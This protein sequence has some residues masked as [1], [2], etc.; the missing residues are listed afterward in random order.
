MIKKV[1]PFAKPI[2]I[3]FTKLEAEAVS[4]WLDDIDWDDIHIA[5]DGCS[6]CTDEAHYLD[7][8]N[9]TWNRVEGQAWK[10]DSDSHALTVFDEVGLECLMR[11]KDYCAEADEPV[12]FVH[13]YH[14]WKHPEVP[15]DQREE[16]RQGHFAAN[17]AAEKIKKALRAEMTE[18]E[19][20]PV[21][22]RNAR[23][24]ELTA[25]AGSLDKDELSRMSAEE[26]VRRLNLKGRA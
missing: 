26:I 13:R 17:R 16:T 25:F 1:T 15:E 11:T 4:Y 7:T 20:S 12:G 9:Y 5:T 14:D 19:M 3:E 2:V 21:R 8:D 6:G 22:E 18:A 24:F 23:M 10:W